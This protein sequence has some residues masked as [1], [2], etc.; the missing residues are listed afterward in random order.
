MSRKKNDISKDDRYAQTT[1]GDERDT[2]PYPTDTPVMGISTGVYI[3][4]RGAVIRYLTE[5]NEQRKKLFA[6]HT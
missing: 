3:N 2:S 5:K 4:N 1:V 6:E